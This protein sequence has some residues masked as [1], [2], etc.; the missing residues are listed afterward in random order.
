MKKLLIT[1]ALVLSSII[2][3]AQNKMTA[4]IMGGALYGHSYGGWVSIGNF[5][6]EH[7]RGTAKEDL[8]PSTTNFTN[9]LVNYYFKNLFIGVGTQKLESID[10][11]SIQPCFSVGKNFIIKDEFII[12]G[13]VLTG[14]K[15]ITTLNLGLGFK[16]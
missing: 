11:N 13:Q 12:R 1:S 8:F 5:G 10:D 16:F 3:N 6:L 4:G 14:G 7:V 2:L 9:V 15:G